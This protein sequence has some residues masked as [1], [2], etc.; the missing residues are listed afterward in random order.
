MLLAQHPTDVIL[1]GLGVLDDRFIEQSEVHD[2]LG[3]G[4]VLDSG[5]EEE[6]LP[7]LVRNIIPGQL[8]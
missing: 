3:I 5:V 1:Q 4:D 7:E 8:D 2:H 6:S